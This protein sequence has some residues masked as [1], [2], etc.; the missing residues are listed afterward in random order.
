M[1]KRWKLAQERRTQ[2]QPVR[3]HYFNYLYAYAMA[4]CNSLLA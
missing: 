2:L 3:S 4:F 1:S